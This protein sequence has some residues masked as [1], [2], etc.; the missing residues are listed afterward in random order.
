[1]VDELLQISNNEVLPKGEHSQFTPGFCPGDDFWVSPGRFICFCPTP[2]PDMYFYIFTVVSCQEHPYLA[3]PDPHAP[4]ILW[5][6]QNGHIAW[7][8]GRIQ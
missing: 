3:L 2:F 8:R 1:M 6:F 4:L 7:V 5:V